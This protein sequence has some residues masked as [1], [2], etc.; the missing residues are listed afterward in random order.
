M[1]PPTGPLA[2]RSSLAG[3]ALALTASSGALAQT[4]PSGHAPAPELAT[5]VVTA[6][7]VERTLKEAP[8]SVSVITREDIESRPMTELADLLGTVEG[9]T[10]SRSGNLVPGVQIRG[11]GQAY[12]LILIDGK[13]VNSTNVMFRGNDYDTGWVPASEIERIEVVRGPMSSLYGSD[14]IGGVVNIITRKVG[15]A[16]RGSA[17]LD[18]VLP[19]NGEAGDGRSASASISGPVVADVL[20]LRVSAGYDKREADGAVNDSGQDGFQRIENKLIGAQLV[21]TPNKDHEVK[22]GLDASKRDHDSFLLEREAFSVTHQGRYGFGMSELTLN[23]DETRNLIGAVSGQVN[24]NKANSNSVNGKFILPLEG[25]GQVLTVGGEY[26]DDKLKDPTNLSGWPGAATTNDPVA[27]VSQ[28]ALFIED[29]ISLGD[30]LKITL[31]NRYDHHE[32]FGGHHSPRAYAVYQ[33]TPALTL[34]TGVAR[35]FRAPTL[36][37]GSTH[38]GSVS[39]GSATVGCYIVGNP[40]LR[41]ETSTSQEIGLHL[42]QGS[43]GAGVTL[44]HSELKD[45]IDIS[46][47]TADP[48]LGATYPNFVGRLADGRPVFAYENIAKV[49]TQGLEASFRVD[50][51][52]QWAVRGSYTYTHARN[53]SAATSTALAYRPRHQANV[54]VDWK[55][56]ERWS[57]QGV[58]RHVG[59]QVTTV[60]NNTT[61]PAYEIIDLSAAFRVNETFTVRTGLLNVADQG[62]QRKD[63]AD[64]N[65]EGR[66][67]F[68]SLSAKF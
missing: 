42:D 7:P 34:K 2:A 59:E 3:I 61:K 40:S 49:R 38:W 64:Y 10:L 23:L 36:L 32:N 52:P 44:F 66:R 17:K 37:Q 4:A 12:T 19:Q 56:A 14:A 27:Q 25:S 48:V 47:R 5:V 35:A 41:P 53:T 26:R 29:E 67:V 55:P 30:R 6:S 50:F 8:A 65:E 31:G 11:M 58:L 1:T 16:W 45:M 9:V 15:K 68:V 57:L 33:I 13:R 18:A 21:W 39:C 46:N 63:S 43:F 28:V 20:G 24:P 60:W 22:L 51:N 62:V 54:T